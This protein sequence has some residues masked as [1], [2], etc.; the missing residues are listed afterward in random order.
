MASLTELHRALFPTARLIGADRLTPDHG[1]R[2]ADLSV[3][4]ART[5]IDALAARTAALSQ[6]PD[7]EQVFCFENR[8]VEIGVTLQHPH[9]QIYAYPFVT[10]RVQK[11][12]ASVA[13]HRDA[14]GGD[15]FAQTVEAE[16]SGPRVVAA[17]EYWTAFVPAAGRW[18]YEVQFFPLRRVPDLPAL[19]DAERDAFVT[20]Y[21]DVL[22]RF[23]R[24]DDELLLLFVEQ[25]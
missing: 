2:F 12:L 16:R 24:R 17:N 22:A 3:P 18:P 15:L 9:G 20:V 6:L 1:A 13:R 11:V 7:V 5:V 23:A 14:T 21:L 4:R 10:P 19:D 8:G 25:G